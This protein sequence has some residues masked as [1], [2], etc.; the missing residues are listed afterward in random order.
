MVVDDNPATLMLMEQMLLSCGYQVHSF[1]RSRMALT[2]ARENPPD[3]ILLDINVPEMTGYEVCEQ[4][5]S[6]PQLSGIS[7][8]FLSGMNALQDRLRGFRA[9]GVDYLS[10]PFRFEEVQARVD[11][12]VR[13]RH[14]QQEIATHECHLQEL[15][16][17]PVK[18]IAA[19]QTETIGAVAKLAEAYDEK[20][21]QLEIETELRASNDLLALERVISGTLPRFSTDASPSALTQSVQPQLCST[22]E[23][24]ETEKSIVSRE[25]QMTM[26]REAEAMH[27]LPD[28]LDRLRQ[29][30]TA[31]RNRENALRQ[32][33]IRHRQVHGCENTVRLDQ[34]RHIDDDTRKLLTATGA[35]REG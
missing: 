18:K 25:L 12:H 19:P 27:G 23:K 20:T 9:G 14:L 15:S 11:V 31:I 33:F 5:K 6:I 7:V 4:I 29:V 16:Q 30:A 13:L 8:I 21:D 26:Q 24:L 28:V 17:I 35:A 1:S 32:E 34:A 2:A 22:C 3:L 10:K